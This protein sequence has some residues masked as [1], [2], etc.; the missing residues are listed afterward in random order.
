MEDGTPPVSWLSDK[1]SKLFAGSTENINALEQTA[2]AN[3]GSTPENK[4][5]LILLTAQ[6]KNTRTSDDKNESSNEI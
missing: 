5:V 3:S 6:S 2:G 4:I 1:S